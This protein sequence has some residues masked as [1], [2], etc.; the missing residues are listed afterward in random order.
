MKLHEVIYFLESLFPKKLAENWDNSGLQIGDL[1]SEIKKVLIVLDISD[2]VVKLAVDKKYDLILTH[3]PFIFNPIKSINTADNIGKLIKELIKNNINLYTMHTNLDVCLTGVNYALAQKLEIK[4]YSLLSINNEKNLYKLYLYVPIDHA[5]FMRQKLFKVKAGQ[6]GDYE[7]CSFNFNGMATF[8]PQEDSDPYIGSKNEINYVK[9]TKIEI[10][11]EENKINRIKE[12]IHKFHPY[13]EPAFDIIKL[14]NLK[15]VYGYGGIGNI[16][17]C[18]LLD[19]AK[20]VKENLNCSNIRLYCND[21]DKKVQRIAFCGGSGSSFINDAIRKK[22]D[23][24]ITGDL[25][26]H[27]IQHALSNDLSLIDAGHYYTEVPV[28]KFLKNYLVEQNKDINVDIL[29]KNY[30]EEIVI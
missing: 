17:E 5:E 2:S 30:I 21:Q 13:E 4:N 1:N 12:T 22:A 25:K 3:H 24:Y 10:I 26:Y 15:E 14:E 18:N 8:Y 28:L 20:K 29:E 27:D 19:Y 11:V 6:I 7:Y 16:I 23:V 9:E